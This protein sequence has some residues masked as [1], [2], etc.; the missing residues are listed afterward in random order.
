MLK[1]PD[2]ETHSITVN[3]EVSGRS[4]MWMREAR[5]GALD[6]GLRMVR[7]V[8]KIRAEAWSTEKQTTALVGHVKN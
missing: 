6:C 5:G 4:E 8:E 3:Q 7:G 2:L 1:C